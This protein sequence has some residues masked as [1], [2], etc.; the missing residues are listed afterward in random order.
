MEK[1]CILFWRAVF[2]FVWHFLLRSLELDE[3]HSVLQIRN[4]TDKPSRKV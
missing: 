1:L 4:L 2:H 3:S